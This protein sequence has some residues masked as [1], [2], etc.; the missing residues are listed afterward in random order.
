MP[1]SSHVLEALSL[2]ENDKAKILGLTVGKH[3][4]VQPGDYIP[5]ADAQ[6]PPE[7]TFAPLSPEKTYLATSVDIDAPFASFAFLSPILHWVQPGLQAPTTTTT[8][9]LQSKAPV[10]ASYAPPGPPPG[11]APH[12]YI[13]LLYEQP[14]GFEGWG[15]GKPVARSQRMRFAYDAWVREVQLGPVLAVNF[16]TSN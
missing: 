2:I 14:A 15:G 10:V 5:R 3:A 13:F 11:S 7:L 6:S 8:T 12:R 9:T 4:N 1:K 16:F